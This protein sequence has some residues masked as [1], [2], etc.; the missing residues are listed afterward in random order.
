MRGVTVVPAPGRRSELGYDPL[1]VPAMQNFI[2]ALRDWEAF[3][4]GPEGMADR[5]EL[6]LR[7]LGMPGRF[8]HR[9]ELSMS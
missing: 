4:C 9:E 3:I 5:A 7:E 8:I 2:P 6:T 1:D